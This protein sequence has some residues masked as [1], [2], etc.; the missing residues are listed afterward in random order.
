MF[1]IIP[2]K[3]EHIVPLMDQKINAQEREFF[4]NGLG[5]DFEKRGTC[6]TGVIN[7]KIAICG[8]I[9]EIWQNRG[10]VWCVFNEEFK[11]N[12]VPVFRLIQKFLQSSNF[13]RIEVCVPFGFNIG[14]RR[15]RMLGFQLEIECARKYLPN[16]EDCAVY[17]LVKE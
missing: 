8:A 6:F 2:Y 14:R 5:R 10:V 9:E 15:A 4:L 16:G 12:F 11:G 1:D 3:H 13:R 7:G 17:S